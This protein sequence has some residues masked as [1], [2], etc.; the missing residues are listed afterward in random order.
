[1]AITQVP[2]FE[3]IKHRLIAD[4]K[5][6][7]LVPG[8]RIAS[9]TEL[10]ERH[11]VAR[12]TVVRSLNEMAAEGYL[13]R[14]KGKGTFVRVHRADN[15]KARTLTGVLALVL[16]EVRLGP[17]PSLVRG[18]EAAAGEN[19]HQVLLC[20]TDNDVRKQG[21]IVLQLI[22]KRVAGV[23]LLPTSVGPAAAHQIRQLQAAGIP[24]VFLHRGVEGASASLIALPYEEVGAA[25]ARAMVDAGHRRVAAFFSHD[26]AHT[27]MYEQ[28]LRQTLAQAGVES[29][30]ELIHVGR[31]FSMSVDEHE[32]GI[33]QALERMLRLPSDRRPTAIFDPWDPEAALIYLLLSK[34][35]VRIPEDI[36]I[37]TFGSIWRL[38]G[39]NQ[40][41]AAVAVDEDEVGRN[42]VGML[43]E[44]ARKEQRNDDAAR[45]V[46]SLC[47][48]RGETLGPPSNSVRTSLSR[49]RSTIM[50][51]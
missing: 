29:N 10:M 43:D 14:M 39:I 27:R 19:N 9:E 41:L 11:G 24:V 47:F 20:N 51:H 32:R 17:Y 34:L 45:S 28:G 31:L 46:I 16:P 25:A 33:E 7:V 37:V 40:R 21:D 48:Y 30:D 26:S 23:A 5:A 42:A 8:T 44:I 12:M 18:F 50:Q 49:N 13:V 3:Q 36:S 2:K 15:D 6:G 1:M 4:I 38:G 22:D 35:G